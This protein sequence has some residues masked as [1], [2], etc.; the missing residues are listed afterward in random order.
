MPP[1]AAAAA[2]LVFIVLAVIS[3][4]TPVGAAIIFVWLWG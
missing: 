3:V 4:F 1:L 2:V